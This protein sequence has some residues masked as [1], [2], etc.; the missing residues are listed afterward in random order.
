M[1]MFVGGHF[2]VRKIRKINR[3][4]I[5]IILIHVS[6]IPYY[7]LLQPT[8]AQLLYKS[9]YHNSLLCNLYSNIFRHI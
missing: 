3:E 2:I 5:L 7:F 4:T 1:F 6:R 8:N 9:V